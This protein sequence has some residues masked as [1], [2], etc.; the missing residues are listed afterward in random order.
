MMLILCKRSSP[1][2]W[3]RRD[4][5]GYGPAPRD[6]QACTCFSWSS[7]IGL[8]NWF[9]LPFLVLQPPLLLSFVFIFPKPLFILLFWLDLMSLWKS[10]PK[11]LQTKNLIAHFF[12]SRG[13]KIFRC[14]TEESIFIPFFWKEWLSFSFQSFKSLHFLFTVYSSHGRKRKN[15]NFPINVGRTVFSFTLPS[16][17]LPNSVFPVFPF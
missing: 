15:P 1:G 16:Q 17:D 11:L 8:N 12:E 10:K 6:S 7:R 9:P 4:V 13:N 14:F 5:N 3:L 2:C